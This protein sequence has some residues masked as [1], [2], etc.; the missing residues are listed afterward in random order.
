MSPSLRST[1]I[2]QS[3]SSR[4]SI[5][6]CCG[7]CKK[8][9]NGKEVVVCAVCCDVFDLSCANVSKVLFDEINKLLK[10][11]KK[12]CFNWTC[13]ICA[14]QQ[15]IV[16]SSSSSHK[17][18][19]NEKMGVLQTL[20]EPKSSDALDAT[21]DDFLNKLDKK[22]DDLLATKLNPKIDLLHSKIIALEEKLASYELQS[23][24]ADGNIFVAVSNAKNGAKRVTSMD[25]LNLIVGNIQKN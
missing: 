21:M 4:A 20:N 14:D 3:T 10:K 16:A 1:S 23:S 19:A 25:E 17:Q 11:S 5:G 13:S 18:M 22:I 2:S 9:L 6:K 15:N 7:S 24:N 8:S 12:Q